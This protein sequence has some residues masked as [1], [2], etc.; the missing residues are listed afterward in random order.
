MSNNLKI[1]LLELSNKYL[2][3]IIVG[4]L[5]FM[6][7]VT[8]L[9]EVLSVKNSCHTDQ[10]QFYLAAKAIEHKDDPYQKITVL[11]SKYKSDCKIVT[12]DYGTP[13]P[14]SVLTALYLLY[15]KYSLVEGQYIWLLLQLSII[16]ISAITAIKSLNTTRQQISGLILIFILIYSDP[17]I[18]DLKFGNMS[19]FLALLCYVLTKAVKAKKEITTGVALGLLLSIKLFS[20]PLV[21]CLLIIKRFQAVLIALIIFTISFALPFLF[22]DT[23]Q[24]IS[25]INNWN[26]ISTVN[27]VVDYAYNISLFSIAY[28]VF[29]ADRNIEISHYMHSPLYPNKILFSITYIST[30]ILYL[31]SFIKIYSTKELEQKINLAF[32]ATLLFNLICW[33]HYIIILFPIIWK[34]KDKIIKSRTKGIA[35]L[36]LISLFMLLLF[37]SANTIEVSKLLNHSLSTLPLLGMICLFVVYNKIES[38]EESNNEGH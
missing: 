18:I 13:Y 32:F 24:S 2:K 4:F 30:Y 1:K 8:N 34:L 19:I 12:H 17:I 31:I 11:N 22:F 23:N 16:I 9:N 20:I 15:K 25:L 29:G 37:Y 38:G 35:A 21:F 14:P 6:L 33:H 5:V 28:R 3:Y 27:A 10:L 36:Y 26:P 7:G